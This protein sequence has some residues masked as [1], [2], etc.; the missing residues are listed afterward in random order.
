M[1]NL[2]VLTF[3]YMS[4]ENSLIKPKPAAEV[5]EE[6]N[7]RKIEAV[8]GSLVH[9]QNLDSKLEVG[10]DIPFEMQAGLNLHP[11]QHAAIPLKRTE[12]FVPEVSPKSVYPSEPPRNYP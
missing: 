6:S 11:A 5:I 3:I 8:L 2:F 1:V 10:T 9:G 7:K 12:T 4:F